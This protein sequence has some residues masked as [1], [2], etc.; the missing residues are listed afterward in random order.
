MSRGWGGGR[1]RWDWVGGSPSGEAD[2]RPGDGRGHR[3]RQ[4]VPPPPCRSFPPQRSRTGRE[5]RWRRRPCSPQ[6][7]AANAVSGGLRTAGRSNPTPY[8]AFPYGGPFSNRGEGVEGGC[9]PRREDP[10]PKP[11]AR[12]AEEAERATRLSQSAARMHGLTGSP[13]NRSAGRGC[14]ARPPGWYKGGRPGAAVAGTCVDSLLV[15]TSNQAA[16]MRECISIHVGQAGVQI[17]NACWELYCLEHGIQPDGQMPS[18]KTIGG[19]D[20]SFNTFF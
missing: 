10:P 15:G 2:Y 7:Y 11:A 13:A 17:G 9:T 18:D 16:A 20:D 5:G 14:S 6:S 1:C 4:H 3:A 12:R 19:G 8:P